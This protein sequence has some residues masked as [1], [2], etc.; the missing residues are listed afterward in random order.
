MEAHHDTDLRI[1]YG[2]SGV[3]HVG[4][5]PQ[6]MRSADDLSEML[7]SMPDFMW[8]IMELSEN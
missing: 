6:V 7:G 1:A 5:G 2:P 3:G 8:C 4:Q